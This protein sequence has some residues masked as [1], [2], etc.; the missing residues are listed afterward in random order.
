MVSLIFSNVQPMIP[1]AGLCHVKIQALRCSGKERGPCGHWH[2]RLMPQKSQLVSSD[3]VQNLF[4]FTY[5]FFKSL[6]RLQ[7]TKE[8][9]TL[10]ARPSHVSSSLSLSHGMFPKCLVH[11]F[12]EASGKGL[13]LQ[14]DG[15]RAGAHSS[16]HRHF[17]KCPTNYCENYLLLGPGRSILSGCM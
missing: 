2:T 10:Q 8:V 5:L 9:D 17:M 1:W 12:S 13:E 11:F 4:L 7:C 6:L 14:F 3:R 15:M 16:L